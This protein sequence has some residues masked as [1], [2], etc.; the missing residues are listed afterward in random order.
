M[1]LLVAF[2]IT[3][4]VTPFVISL[5]KKYGLVDDP[6]K[7][8][9]PATTHVGIIPRA[10]GLAIYIGTL[11]PLMLLVPLN[12]FSVGIILATTLLMLI[13][14]LDDKKDVHPYIRLCTNAI[15]ALFVIASGVNIPY[16]TNP[17][18]LGVIQLDNWKITLDLFGGI[19][20]SV[21]A[22]L[23]AFLWIVWTM[24]IVGWSAGVDG[25][26]PGFV[27]ISAFVL[28]ILSLRFSQQD[29]SQLFV[30]TLAFIVTGSFLGFIPWNF[31]PQKIMPGYG[32]KTL[33]GF[34]LGILGILSY[35]KVGTALLVLGVPM[36]DALYTLVRRL[37][38]KRSPVWGDR[39]HLHHRLLDLGWSKR[40]IAL[41][42][43]GLS[44]ILGLVALSVTSKQKIFT[45][46][47]T[48]VSVGAFLVWVHFLSALSKPS[49]P[50][51]G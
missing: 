13:G 46:L 15:A 39:G 8:F 20:I 9:H 35:A 4:G 38:S 14:L 12:Q 22:D 19:T 47:L 18:G 40:K 3:F 25:Q 45:L 2:L 32:G 49:D 30:T 6:K 43:W 21:W 1:P 31:F 11:L 27:A 42:Y 36:I 26:M 37:G 5:A 17:F 41:F 51:N 50:D 24:N 34:L 7:R 16:I 44:S 10:G 48:A 28:G 29:T 33:A 23:L